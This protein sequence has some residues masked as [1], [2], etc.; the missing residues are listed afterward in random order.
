MDLIFDTETTGF[1]K[2][3]TPANDPI[4]PDI[5]Q[6]GMILADGAKIISS[7]S[8]IVKPEKKISEGAIEAH[9]IT[10][11]FAAQYGVPRKVASRLFN[12]LASKV[13][14]IIAHNIDFDMG[15]MATAYLR[16]G[17]DF[18]KIARILTICTMKGTNDIIKL[19]GK[20]GKFKWPT[21]EE[22]YEF[23]L[24]KPIVRGA[25]D[26]LEDSTLCHAILCAARE[27]GHF[28]TLT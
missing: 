7:I 26:A 21:L 25:H 16:S 17:D 4:Q 1:F 24:K 11:E 9:G 23:F 3:G 28:K 18:S 5:V 2:F 22:A 27:Q 20:F 6:L 8:L 10:E 19:P 12:Q 15:V 13:D 14:C